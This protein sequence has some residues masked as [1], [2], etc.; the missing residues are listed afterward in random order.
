MKK[1]PKLEARR[2]KINKD[3]DIF[4]NKSFDMADRIHALLKMKGM[5]QKDLANLLG[6]N[7][8]EISKWLTGTHN[9]TMRTLSTIEQVLGSEV[10]IAAGKE[11]ATGESKIIYVVAAPTSIAAKQKLSKVNMKGKVSIYERTHNIKSNA[12]A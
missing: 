4:V 5:E 2:K 1:N 9:F 11:K 10:C 7:E 3:I 12:M 6:K 8:S